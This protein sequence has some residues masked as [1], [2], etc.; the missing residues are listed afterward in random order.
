MPAAYIQFTVQRLFGEFYPISSIRNR[1]EKFKQDYV[2]IT[3]SDP[4]T[5]L[6]T[7]Y[8]HQHLS[9]QKYDGM[10]KPYKGIN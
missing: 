8:H 10:S 6:P 5:S 7:S 9:F 2:C 4:S 1:N 3:V